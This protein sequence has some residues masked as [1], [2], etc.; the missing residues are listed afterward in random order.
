[1]PRGR[2]SGDHILSR[3]RTADLLREL[4]ALRRCVR[5]LKARLVA[6]ED[7]EY[8][9]RELGIRQRPN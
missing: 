2:L 8:R 1:M 4:H 5:I 7:A 3:K 6:E 9:R